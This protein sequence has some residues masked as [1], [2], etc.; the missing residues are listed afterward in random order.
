MKQGFS[1]VE[2]SIVLVILGLLTGGILAGQSLIRAAELRAVAT[3]TNRWLT[4]ANSFRDKYFALPGDITNATK[5]WGSA[6]ACPGTA[7]SGTQTCNGNGD[8]RVDTPIAASN[9]A[10]NFTFWQHLANAG[11]IEGA[12]SGMSGSGGAAHSTTSNVPKSK[13]GQGLWF[14]AW[15][16]SL[17]GFNVAGDSMFT[18][19]YG[20]YLEVGAPTTNFHPQSVLLKPE[21]MWNLDTKMDDGKPAIGRVIARRYDTCTT[22]SSFTDYAAEYALTSSAAGCVFL[23]ARAF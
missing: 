7:G 21:E 9:Y 4:A 23:Y 10:D 2:L 14:V 16:G 11:L 13:L 5:F 8:G 20:N 17:T 22:A 6:P 15:Q 18:G 3:E 12:Y 19:D 1:L